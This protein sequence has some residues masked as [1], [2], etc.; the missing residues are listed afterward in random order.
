MVLSFATRHHA[1]AAQRVGVVTRPGEHG[2]KDPPGARLRLE[3]A[4]GAQDFLGVAVDLDVGEH[5]ADFALFVHDV[6]DALSRAPLAPNAELVDELAVRV[7]EQREIGAAGD[8]VL[9][10]GLAVVDAD[11]DELGV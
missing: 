5:V 9:L 7:R 11:A 1:G 10:L 2:G 8:G 3:A 6:G 4:Q